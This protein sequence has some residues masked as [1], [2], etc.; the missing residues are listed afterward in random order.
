MGNCPEKKMKHFLQPLLLLHVLQGLPPCGT[1]SASEDHSRQIKDIKSTLLKNSLLPQSW[2]L[3]C[4]TE[5]LQL[6]LYYLTLMQESTSE[7][8]TN[9]E[10]SQALNGPVQITEGKYLDERLD[11][12]TV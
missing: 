4:L 12:T 7:V 2:T 3:R 9:E 5:C 10:P 6:Q 8:L 1:V 11:K